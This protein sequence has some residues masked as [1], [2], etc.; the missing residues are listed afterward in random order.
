MPVYNSEKYLDDAIKSILNQTFSDFELIIIDDNSTDDSWNIIQKY[1]KK[2]KRIKSFRNEENM[3]CTKSLNQGLK[4][5]KGKYIARMDSDDVSMPKRFEEQIKALKDY[6]VI[7]SNIIFFDDKGKKLGKRKYSND[8]DK[9]IREESPL[10]HP[11]TMFK[12][13][14]LKNKYYDERFETA[15]DY[16]LWIRF[17]LQGANFFIIQKELLL[18]RLHPT[19]S[20]NRKT[21]ITIRNTIK[22]K[23]Q[24]KKQGL[25]IGFR[26]EIRLLL[27]RLSLLMPRQLII[28]LFKK[29]K[30]K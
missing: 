11:S 22:I 2:D 15:Q 10:A 21:K 24:A 30:K 26:G 23:K 20:K 8:I 4:Q 9:I 25:K 3:G 16:A 27:E 12:R 29:L 14:L 7:G 13:S 17:Y 1:A 18:Y 6:D 5:A 28:F 19:A